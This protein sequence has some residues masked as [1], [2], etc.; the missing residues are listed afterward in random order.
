MN[1]TQIQQYPLWIQRKSNNF[2]CTRV[3]PEPEIVVARESSDALY[4]YEYGD[5]DVH[6]L[7]SVGTG[8]GLRPNL[9][10]ILRIWIP[11][12]SISANKMAQRS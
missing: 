5:V 1:P 12:Y 10:D 2:C 7:Q 9:T 8:S 11:T 6:D 3:Q 4:L